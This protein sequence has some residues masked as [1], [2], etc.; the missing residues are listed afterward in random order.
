RQRRRG[1]AVAPVEATRQDGGHTPAE[2]TQT[3]R[4]DRRR[5]HPV[6]VVVAEDDDLLASANGAGQTARCRGAVHHG[7]RRRQCGQAWMEERIERGT[8]NEAA[9]TQI[10]TNRSATQ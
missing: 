2:T 8:R 6:A 7:R 1:E 3:V 10:R 5:R 9:L 4:Q